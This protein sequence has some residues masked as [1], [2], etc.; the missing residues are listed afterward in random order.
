MRTKIILAFIFISIFIIVCRGQQSVKP[1]LTLSL[2]SQGFTRPTQIL[3][4]AVTAE[5]L[6]VQQTG[7]ITILDSL[8]NANTTPFLDIT[9]KVK[10]AGTEQGLLGLAFSPEYKKDSAFYVYYTNFNGPSGNIVISRFH[11]SN[12]NL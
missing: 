2:F 6:I 12:N 8:G 11:R 7:K 4:I 9:N 5:Y 1:E 3:K 10:S